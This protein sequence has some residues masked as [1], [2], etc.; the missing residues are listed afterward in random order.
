MVA[1]VRC[2]SCWT[3]SETTDE[4][5]D[6]EF[7]RFADNGPGSADMVRQFLQSQPQLMDNIR[8]RIVNRKLFTALAERFTV[9]DVPFEEMD[10]E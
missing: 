2:C 7:E 5:W 6:E 3:I 8:E 1:P 4:D 10:Q 9:V